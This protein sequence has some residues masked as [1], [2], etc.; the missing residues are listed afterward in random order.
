[1]ETESATSVKRVPAPWDLKGKGYILLYKFP[2]N[3]V[4]E[5]GSIPA[6]LGNSFAG[7]LGAVMIVDYTQSDAGP[8]GE[9]LFIPGKF[10]FNQQ[11]LN[12][13]TKIYVSTRESVENG[14]ANWAIPKKLA[15]FSFTR[16]EGR[17]RK[18]RAVVKIE[19]E[20]ILDITLR[21]GK[22]TF[23]IHTTLI[24]FPLVQKKDDKLYHTNFK[25][26]GAAQLA[27]IENIQVNPELFPDIALYRPL[28][29]LRVFNFSITFPVAHITG[30]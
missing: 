3:F 16:P 26:K 19:K 2:K 12:C 4:M 7:G 13:I 14:W 5:N 10:H 22:L 11:K 9:L 15:D 6:F 25:G 8:Y 27:Q 29:V 30:T 18:E 20:A 24:P 21:H 1:M 23:P 28:I 17:T